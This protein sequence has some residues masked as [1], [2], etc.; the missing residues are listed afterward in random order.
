MPN[1]GPLRIRPDISKAKDLLNW[2]S[3]P[4]LEQGLERTMQWFRMQ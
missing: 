2:Q 3:K 4:G 1:D